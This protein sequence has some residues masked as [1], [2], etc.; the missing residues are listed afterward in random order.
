MELSDLAVSFYDVAADDP[1]ESF[2]QIANRNVPRGFGKAKTSAA[3]RREARK[4]FNLA[5]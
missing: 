5:R 4:I 1:Q 2:D 3:F